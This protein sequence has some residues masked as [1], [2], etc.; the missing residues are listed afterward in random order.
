MEGECSEREDEKA[1]SDLRQIHIE[2]GEW[3]EWMSTIKNK[4]EE[5]ISYQSNG[6]D[7]I[8]QSACLEYYC[9][10]LHDDFW[11]SGI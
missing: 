6:Y 9:A 5:I 11:K 3:L 4:I 10:N 2:R 7:I 8:V 1:V